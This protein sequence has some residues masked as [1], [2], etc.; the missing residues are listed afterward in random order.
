M[1][2]DVRK[3][4]PD[5]VTLLQAYLD[6]Q[7][8]TWAGFLLGGLPF[9]FLLVHFFFFMTILY[10]LTKYSECSVCCIGRKKRYTLLVTCLGL[11]RVYNYSLKKT[12]KRNINGASVA[13]NTIVI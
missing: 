13:K 2:S 8:R 5:K 6:A 12:G 11:T 7:Q 10:G 9:F 1:H 3:G 4:E